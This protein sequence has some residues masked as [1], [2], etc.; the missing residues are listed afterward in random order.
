MFGLEPQLPIDL[1]GR[2][3][4]PVHGSVHSWVQD[5]QKRLNVAYEGARKW[6]QTAAHKRAERCMVP[7]SDPLQL[8]QLVFL[9]T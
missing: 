6:L 4:E 2:V 8:H 3:E 5:H 7:A 1:L 9:R